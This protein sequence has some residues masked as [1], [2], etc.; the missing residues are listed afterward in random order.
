[1]SNE[2][3]AAVPPLVRLLRRRRRLPARQRRRSPTRS[4]PSR[5]AATSGTPTWWPP[6][7]SPTSGCRTWRT[8]RSRSPSW[9]PAAPARSP[10]RCGSLPGPATRSPASR[11]RC[12]T[13]TTWPATPG[14]WWPPSTPP[15]T[16]ASSTTR[17]RS[18]S[19]CR[20]T[21]VTHG[22]EA[23]ADEVAAAELRLKFR[24]GGVEAHLFPS[25][26]QVVSWI[27]AALDRELR[28]KCT[29][30]LHNAVRHRDPDTGFEHHGFLN[31]L[32]A[33]ARGCSTGGSG[34]GRR[35]RG[36]VTRAPS[37]S[38]PPTSTSPGPAGGSPASA[39]A[40][41]SN[42]SPT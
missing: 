9:S 16:R 32:V 19:S 39:P 24:T 36:A 28:F 12:A 33:T 38:A 31:V 37:W 18:S 25:A 34:R 13:P 11:S 3:P 23:A 8:R 10:A 4:R 20:P 21:D 14:G 29:A 2:L 42:P 40:R 35:P 6:S 41:S 17:R 7:S 22:W 15:A 5:L 1:M 26:D 30:G 27:D